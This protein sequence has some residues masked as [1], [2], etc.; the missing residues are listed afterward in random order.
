MVLSSTEQSHM[1]EFT[2][3]PLSES[4]QLQVAANS[5]GKLQTWHLSPPVGYYM[6]KYS[7]IAVYY[8]S[9]IYLPLRLWVWQI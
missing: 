5:L 7:P 4:H 3:G 9:T 1:R 8:Y 2:L 6:P